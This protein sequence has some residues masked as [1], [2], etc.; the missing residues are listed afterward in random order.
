MYLFVILW[1]I[2]SL[3]YYSHKYFCTSNLKMDLDYWKTIRDSISFWNRRK[4]HVKSSDHIS[5]Y[6]VQ[7]GL[8]LYLPSSITYIW[9][10]EIL[11][12]VADCL[13]RSRHLCNSKQHFSFDFFVI[14]I[15]TEAFF[16][17]RIM[18]IS[19]NWVWCA[20]EPQKHADGLWR[21]SF[22]WYGL[23]SA[24]ED[25]WYMKIFRNAWLN[26][27]NFFCFL[28]PMIPVYYYYILRSSFQ[29]LRYPFKSRT[30]G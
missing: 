3:V 6:Y 8:Y 13:N 14:L 26:H 16:F 29:L 11:I 10:C 15:V 27:L 22:R 4:T 7:T 30:C 18:V 28:K 20:T 23:S 1:N 17:F 2:M 9:Y 24:A 25:L 5:I 12:H 19:W 21:P